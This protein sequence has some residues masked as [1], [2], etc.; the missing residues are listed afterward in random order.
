MVECSVFHNETSVDCDINFTAYHTPGCGPYCWKGMW[1]GCSVI[2]CVIGLFIIFVPIASRHMK[3]IR[4]A[5]NTS[6]ARSL[7]V[8]PYFWHLNAI[9]LLVVVYDAIILSQ[10]HVSGSEQVEIGVIVSKLLTVILIFQLNFTY[11]PSTADGFPLICL[12]L[13][14]MTL[15][16]FVLDNLCKFVELTVRISYKLYT[17][18]SKRSDRELQVISLML[19]IVDATLYHSF[20]TF[21]WNKIFR[22]RSDVL[23]TY[24]PDLAQSLRVQRDDATSEN[25]GP[26]SWTG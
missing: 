19:E 15:S 8:K 17:V 14:Y 21:F 2:T 23:M 22:G 3:Q 16:I 11:P 5:S 24:S 18:N 1:I 25:L 26:E 13:Y 10:E 4:P 9:V 6:I 12:V 7:I 20:A